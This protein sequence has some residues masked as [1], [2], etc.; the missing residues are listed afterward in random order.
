MLLRHARNEGVAGHFQL[1]LHQWAPAALDFF[2]LFNDLPQ[3][4]VHDERDL[5][6]FDVEDV[7]DEKH[8]VQLVLLYF[9]LRSAELRRAVSLTM[10]IENP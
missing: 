3:K 9:S 7:A 2:R 10:S 1:G 4:K 8:F 5:P 6:R